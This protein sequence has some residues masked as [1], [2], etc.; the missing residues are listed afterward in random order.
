[1]AKATSALSDQ[2]WL[3]TIPNVKDNVDTTLAE[4]SK[5]TQARGLCRL[6][7][8]EVP[9]L[10]HGTLDTLIALSDDLGK[11]NQNVEVRHAS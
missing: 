6:H 11:F 10:N 3:I 8:F 1:M 7:K 4:L 5:G 2:L 9:A